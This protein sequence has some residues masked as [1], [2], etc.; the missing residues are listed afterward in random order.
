MGGEAP[1]P[2]SLSY[3]P[4]GFYPRQ[5][6]GR[7]RLLS[8]HTCWSN[9]NNNNKYQ[10]PFFVLSVPY[11]SHQHC[12]LSSPDLARTTCH[13]GILAPPPTPYGPS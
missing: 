12:R 9:K 1:P 3:F 10:Q 11:P 7:G 4:L 5:G 6:K 13:S 2:P 8:I